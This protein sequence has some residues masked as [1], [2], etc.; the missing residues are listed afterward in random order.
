VTDVVEGL[1]S[2]IDSEPLD[3]VAAYAGWNKKGGKKEMSRKIMRKY[4]KKL[5][6]L[7]ILKTD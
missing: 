3:N 4:A 5:V 7:P 1:E 6:V 2:E